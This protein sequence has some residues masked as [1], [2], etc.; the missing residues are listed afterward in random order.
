[1]RRYTD[2]VSFYSY[3]IPNATQR[4]IQQLPRLPEMCI[5]FQTVLQ[6]QALIKLHYRTI[7]LHSRITDWSPR[8]GDGIHHETTQQSEISFLKRR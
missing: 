1:M 6:L 2:P 7:P 4:T 5:N 8:E 3:R